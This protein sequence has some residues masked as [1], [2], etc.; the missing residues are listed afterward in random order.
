MATIIW[1]T[2]GSHWCDLQECEAHLLEERIYPIDFVPD[3]GVPYHVRSRK[4]SLGLDCNLA[5]YH[6]RWA[7]TNPEHDPFAP[8]AR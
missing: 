1:E 8:L 3:T 2:V 6:C 5:G 7:W 4:C